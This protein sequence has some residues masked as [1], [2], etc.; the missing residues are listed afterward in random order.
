MVAAHALLCVIEG[1]PEAQV[2]T[3]KGVSNRSRQAAQF[4]SSIPQSMEH[5]K[6]S[7]LRPKHDALQNND[8]NEI[9]RGVILNRMFGYTATSTD[10]LLNHTYWLKS[11]RSQHFISV[12]G[13]GSYNVLCGRSCAFPPVENDGF[14]AALRNAI[15]GSRA[16]ASL[17]K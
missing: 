9:Y 5:L 12:S 17:S 1:S 3:E 4:L 14:T 15:S 2:A 13:H 10:S 16:W 7:S 6:G 8:K 11:D